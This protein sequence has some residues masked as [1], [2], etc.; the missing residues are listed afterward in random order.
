MYHFLEYPILWERAATAL[1]VVDVRQDS[2]F[3]YV[4]SGR[5]VDHCGAPKASVRRHP[6]GFALA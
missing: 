5:P 4:N 3:L 1:G 6:S 2:A